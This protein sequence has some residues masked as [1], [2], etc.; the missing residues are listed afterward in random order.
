MKLTV[1]EG[2]KNGAGRAP[3]TKGETSEEVRLKEP[4]CHMSH[5]HCAVAQHLVVPA[6]YIP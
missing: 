5:C 1:W 4:R 6:Y 2:A 3:D